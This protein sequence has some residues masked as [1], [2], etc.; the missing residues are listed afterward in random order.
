M[1][2]SLFGMDYN[3]YFSNFSQQN[4]NELEEKGSV[5][6][7]NVDY[8]EGFDL[9]PDNFTFKDEFLTSVAEYDPELCVELL[10]MFDKPDLE[11]EELTKMLQENILAVSEQV[12][13]EYFSH[14]RNRMYPLIKKSYYVTDR[15]KKKKVDD[16]VINSLERLRD[17]VIFQEDTTF[18]GNYYSMKSLVQNGVVWNQMI[19]LTDLTV[20]FVFKALNRGALRVDYFI[21]PNEDKIF[22]YSV[23]QIQDPP[24]IT[25]ILGRE[26]NIPGSVRKRIQAIIEWFI[27]RIN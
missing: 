4:I 16:P 25:E 3:K 14:N 12:G 21:I 24:H 11:G 8:Q 13:I 2:L 15:K 23:V 17:Y 7:S 20:F 5:I 18:G 22:V 27:K 19:N 10:F 9:I 1:S 6:N 26:V